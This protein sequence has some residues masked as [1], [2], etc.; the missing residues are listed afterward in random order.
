[1]TNTETPDELTIGPL[2]ATEWATLFLPDDHPRA[3]E[4]PLPACCADIS[5]V[6]SALLT[7]FR[8]GGDPTICWLRI[9]EVWPIVLSHLGTPIDDPIVPATLRKI[10]YAYVCGRNLRELGRG[11]GKAR[12]LAQD[13]ARVRQ[14]LATVGEAWPVDTAEGRVRAVAR[15]GG[16]FVAYVADLGERSQL[17]R[18][19]AGAVGMSY[20]DVA[21]VVDAMR[22][23]NQLPWQPA[24]G[25]RVP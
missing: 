18:E 21:L 4:N 24:E 5:E 14:I 25:A 6:R 10:Y 15:V 20:E 16:T 13:P 9:A 8:M 17:I 11:E 12:I 1:M 19:L 2:T 22:C 3:D 23:R 7:A